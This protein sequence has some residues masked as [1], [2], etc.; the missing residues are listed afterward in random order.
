[1][2]KNKIYI[3]FRSGY[4]AAVALNYLQSTYFCGNNLNLKYC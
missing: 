1:M 4:F 3:K 2:K